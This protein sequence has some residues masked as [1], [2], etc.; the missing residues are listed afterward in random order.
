[1]HDRSIKSMTETLWKRGEVNRLISFTIILLLLASSGL[2]VYYTGG[3]KYV[4]PHSMYLVIVAGAAFYGL[5]GALI[6]AVVGGLILGPAMPLDTVTGEH[7]IMINWVLRLTA[8]IVVGSAFGLVIDALRRSLH[9][10][11]RTAYYDSS[12]SLPNRISLQNKL[13][14]DINSGNI[15]SATLIKIS[16][17]SYTDVYYTFGSTGWDQLFR[18][19]HTR[20]QDILPPCTSIFHVQPNQLGVVLSDSGQGA[21]DVV[22]RIASLFQREAFMVAG[23]PLYVEVTSG[24]AQFAQDAQG[25]E[26]LIQKAGIALHA[27]KRYDPARYT[28]YNAQRD[29]TKN[30]NLELLGR[31]SKA[32]TDNEFVLH[33]QPQYNIKD[34]SICGVEALIRWSHPQHGLLYPGSFLPAVEKTALMAD[35]TN[36]VITSALKQLKIWGDEGIDIKVA[37][38]VSA[39]DICD[40]QFVSFVKGEL[41]KH[42]IQASQL[43]LEVTESALMAD[44]DNALYTLDSLSAMGTPIALDDYGTGYTSL[45]RVKTLPINTIK[46]DRTF[47]RNLANDN[48]DKAIVSATITMADSLGISVV[49]EGVEDEKSVNALRELGC[50][51]AQGYYYYKPSPAIDVT[52]ALT[53]ELHRRAETG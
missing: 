35:M 28:H 38:N 15:I 37:V 11:T 42:G 7:Q 51:Q 36:W 27:T 43:E 8:F 12:T 47:I 53:A 21:E 2:L 4:Y 17:D 3:V 9:A 50:A 34:N 32:L 6:T 33:Y 48:R 31:V 10:L 49:A 1:M 40:P 26:D 39:R 14:Q 52:S 46:I 18:Q 25:A 5:R 44:Y 23:V 22:L 24:I 29:W 16:I 19:I 20:L 30:N 45:E 41:N 13:T